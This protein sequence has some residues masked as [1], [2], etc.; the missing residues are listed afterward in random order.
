MEVD[1]AQKLIEGLYSASGPGIA[2][3]IQEQLLA[4]Q[5]QPQA[6]QIASQLLSIEEHIPRRT[7]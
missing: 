6:W 2:K 5:R 3:E 4:I 1:Q 7:Y